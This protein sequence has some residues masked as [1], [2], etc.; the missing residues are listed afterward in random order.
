MA[1]FTEENG[2]N[3]IYF[4]SLNLYLHNSWVKSRRDTFILTNY[5]QRN[6]PNFYFSLFKIFCYECKFFES[7]ATFQMSKNDKTCRVKRDFILLYTKER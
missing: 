4:S 2:K 3:F 5:V 6:K 7:I 1:A